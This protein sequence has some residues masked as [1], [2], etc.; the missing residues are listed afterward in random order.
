[1]TGSSGAAGSAKGGGVFASTKAIINATNSIFALNTAPSSPDFNGT[2]G[3]AFNNIVGINSGSN[4]APGK[5]D[6]NGNWVGSTSSP[7][8]PMLG[9]LANNGGP[10]QTLAVLSGSVAINNGTIFNPTTGALAPTTDE[11]GVIFGT[12]DIGAFEFTL[13]TAQLSGGTLTVNGTTLGDIISVDPVPG[14]PS[15]VQVTGDG[16]VVGTFQ[17]S[18][19]T[20]QITVNGNG[21]N[22]YLSINSSIAIKA[23]LNGGTGNDTL[24]AGAG[25]D[26]LTGGGGN[27]IFNV[28]GSTGSDTLT[29]GSGTGTVISNVDTNFTLTNT[30]LTQSNGGSFSLSGITNAVLTGGPGNNTFNVGGWTGPATLIGGGGTDTVAAVANAKTFTLTDSSLSISNGASFTL[31]GIGQ[32]VLIGGSTTTTMDAS[33]FS[34]VVTLDGGGGSATLTGSSEE[35]VLIAGTGKCTL[36]GGTGGDTILVGDSTTYDAGSAANITSLEAIMA[37]WNSGSSYTTR[38]KHIL[39]TLG[40]G[41]NGSNF[42]NATTVSNSHQADSMTG[43]TGVDA[44]WSSSSDIIT[45][46]EGQRGGSSGLSVPRSKR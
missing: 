32:A 18:A 2:F 1:M 43:G 25:N 41:L 12:P 20:G 38:V 17:A 11:R 42:L 14:N 24:V 9:A 21:G 10:T 22:D 35:S 30:L 36:N 37:E 23:A 40:G 31:S 28:S 26:T 44:F 8:D 19:I 45:D 27:D 13:V 6:A 39:G 4:L 7:T 16:I 46:L 33:G 29:Q 5:P 34:G 3:T 15:Q